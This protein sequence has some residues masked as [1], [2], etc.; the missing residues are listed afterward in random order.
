MSTPTCPT[1]NRPAAGAA[2]NAP[3]MYLRCSLGHVF[4]GG[5]SVEQVRESVAK[6]GAAL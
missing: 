2:F 6:M 1:C 5:D 3:T 4:R